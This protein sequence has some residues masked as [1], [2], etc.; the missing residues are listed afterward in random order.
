MKD[1]GCGPSWLTGKEE[2][3]DDGVDREAAAVSFLSESFRLVVA[4]H[5][6]K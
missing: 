3:D 2:T 6:K 4:V 1:S 5:N